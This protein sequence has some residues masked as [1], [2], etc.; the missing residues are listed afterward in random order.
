MPKIG[1]IQFW[2]HPCQKGK[3]FFGQTADFSL[4]GSR[5]GKFIK[6]LHEKGEKHLFRL[7]RGQ[8]EKFLKKI[9]FKSQLADQRIVKK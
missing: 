8:K 2:L 5:K 6:K 4:L 9:P 3:F 7:H 1:K